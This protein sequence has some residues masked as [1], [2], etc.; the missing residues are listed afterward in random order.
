MTTDSNDSILAGLKNRTESPVTTGPFDGPASSLARHANGPKNVAELRALGES[1]EANKR[2]FDSVLALREYEFSQSAAAITT[3]WQAQTN[4]SLADRKR[5]TEAKISEMRKKFVANSEKERTEM[6]QQAY[7]CEA[8]AAAVAPLFESAVGMLVLHGIND[9]ATQGYV[10]LLAGCGSSQLKIMAVEAANKGNKALGAAILNRLDNMSHAN[11]TACQIN[12]NDLAMTLTGPEWEA[13]QRALAACRNRF[14]E[15]RDANR[16]FL[17]KSK[18][19]NE[20]RNALNRLD[21]RK[22]KAKG[23]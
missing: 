12:R 15:V 4:L 9:P 19:V 8:Q 7:A 14:Y 6:F 18:G 21:E 20:I 22:F 16:A 2:K 11:K 10:T 5:I 23:E 1:A 17:G 3:E 13:A